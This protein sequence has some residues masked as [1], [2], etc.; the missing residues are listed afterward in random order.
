MAGETS[1]SYHRSLDTPDP[2]G[3]VATTW[4]LV[5]WTVGLAAAVFGAGL[6]FVRSS[7]PAL[8]AL[9]VLSAAVLYG[10]PLFLLTWA[11]LAR[12]RGFRHWPYIALVLVWLTTWFVVGLRDFD[13]QT[14]RVRIIV[15]VSLPVVSSAAM[16]RLI[17]LARSRER[18]R[19][20]SSP[21]AT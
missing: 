12:T 4:L 6:T 5:L 9:L 8:W 21:P 20:Q 14:S 2:A 13:D 7:P 16:L 1:V 10:G 17:A 19:I 3:P 11:W 18:T 15:L